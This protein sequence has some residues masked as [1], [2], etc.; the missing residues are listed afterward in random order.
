MEINKYIS[1]RPD[2]LLYFIP[3]LFAIISVSITNPPLA[4]DDL[5]RF[6]TFYNYFKDFSF[7]E[8]ITFIKRLPDFLIPI[9]LYIFSKLGIPVNVLLGL[10]TYITVFIILKI[11]FLILGDRKKNVFSY[12]FLLSAISFSGL[13][14]G[15]RN[16]HSIAFV[17]LAI[18][19]YL[20]NKKLK[21]IGSYLIAVLTHFSSWM[22]VV[23]FGL[24]ELKIKWVYILWIV[25]F[26]GV[27]FPF[28]LFPYMKD[29]IEYSP[30]PII[31]KI[32]HYAFIKDYYYTLTQKDIK[33]IF[34]SF[35]KFS[36]YLFMLIFLF[37]MYKRN[38]GSVWVKILFIVSIIMN[39]FFIQLTIF[40]RISLFAKI[41]FVVCL[42]E[43][44]LVSYKIKKWT[45]AYFL[46][47]F[48]V[49][50]TLYMKGLL[51]LE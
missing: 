28:I 1:S 46:F 47:L 6:Y 36:W 2:F 9:Y 37:F 3:G 39:I 21:A 43:D 15:V 50:I 44:R 11:S 24:L 5:Y 18:Y 17:Y 16:L 4:Y 45:L 33:I 34:A 8:Y 20:K 48:V 23:L 10:I 31:G 40:E 14:S 22:Y 35:L 51:F 7:S 26:V 49:Q 19:L 32:Q 41:L 38:N 27:L 13:L 12:L 29:E 25:S 42:L 30:I